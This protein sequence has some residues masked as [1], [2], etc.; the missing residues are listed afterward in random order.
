MSTL[1]PPPRLIRET[2]F[3]LF[4]FARLGATMSVQMMMLLI[5]WQLYLITGSALDLGLIGLIQF[6]PSVVLTLAIGHAADR[7]D[8]RLIVSVSQAVYA[9]T[10]V[11]IAVALVTQNLNRDLLFTAAFLIGTARAFELPTASA[12]VPALVP[13]ALVPAAVA[14]WTSANQVAVICGPAIGGF[15]YVLSPVAVCIGAFIL[16]GVAIVCVTLI[17]LRE[18]PPTREPPTL[19]SALAGFSYV[20]SRPRLLGV[21]TLDMFVVLSAGAIAL[22]PIYASDILKV[23]PEGLGLLRAAPAAGALITAMMLSR[24]PVDRHIGPQ[25]FIAAAMYSAATVVFGLSTWFPLSLLALFVL[26]T[27]DV[28]SIVIR[29]SLVQLET[30]EAMRG[31][32]SAINYLF[33]NASNTLSEFRAGAMAAWLGAV[34]A[35]TLGGLAA[36]AITGAWML[37]FPG[38]RRLDR[39]EPAETENRP[40]D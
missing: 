25:M 6:V 39:Y 23:G 16:T 18:A 33:I 2:P 11:M 35:M 7:Y 26:G 32:V 38:L 28:V 20:R 40:R 29:F 15:V 9:A 21:I 10:A 37:L 12:L 34:P 19:A 30:P 5:G 24:L 4:W 14:A 13:P 8:R 3:V 36:L 27:S 17:R 22:L 1:V 31:R